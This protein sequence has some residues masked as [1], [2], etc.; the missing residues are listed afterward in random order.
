MTKPDMIPVK[1]FCAGHQLEIS[2]VRSLEEH[3]LIE[4]IIVNQTQWIPTNELPRL[5]QIIRLNRELNINFEGI[6][7]INHL[8]E[9]LEVMQEQIIEL[10]NR[11]SFFEEENTDE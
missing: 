4:T 1:E 9:R 3:G 11:I 10:N 8:L 2:F 7:A 6:D 5:E